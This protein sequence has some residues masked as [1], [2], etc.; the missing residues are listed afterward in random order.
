M[1]ESDYREEMVRLGLKGTRGFAPESPTPY[2]W[3][4]EERR[5]KSQAVL[6]ALR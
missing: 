3:G 5:H 1:N 6:P 2:I 4:K